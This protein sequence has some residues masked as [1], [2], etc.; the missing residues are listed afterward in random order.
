MCWC[1][2]GAWRGE[3]ESREG[4]WERARK[5]GGEGEK[6]WETESLRGKAGD[7]VGGGGGR[8]AAGWSSCLCVVGG[9]EES[10][11]EQEEGEGGKEAPRGWNRRSPSPTVQSNPL[12]RCAV[13]FAD[14]FDRQTTP[15]PSSNPWHCSAAFSV[16]LRT[17]GAV[18]LMRKRG[19]KGRGGGDEG[20]REWAEGDGA[21]ASMV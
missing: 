19:K 21:G 20:L 3:R 1:I 15:R 8:G 7:G 5:K 6:G 13:S 9:V 2:G 17:H 11:G 14:A 12:Y 10:K 16:R 4:L 18:P